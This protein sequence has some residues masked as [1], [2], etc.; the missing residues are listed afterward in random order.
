MRF[1]FACF[2]LCAITVEDDLDTDLVEYS[3]E[4][5]SF[6]LNVRDAEAER[7]HVTDIKRRAHEAA[8]AKWPWS[9]KPE[10]KEPIYQIVP[11]QQMSFRWLSDA[12]EMI[13]QAA[14]LQQKGVG[15]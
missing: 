13:H 3:A 5:L 1:N 12:E 11:I 14:I 10:F 9:P 8:Y 7:I 4:L 15:A 2:A 6:H